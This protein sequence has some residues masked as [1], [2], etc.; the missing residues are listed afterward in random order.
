MRKGII[1]DSFEPHVFLVLR[2]P[3]F[4]E[5]QGLQK[6]M[7]DQSY[8]ITCTVTIIDSS[9]TIQMNIGIF[10]LCSEAKQERRERERKRANV[11]ISLKGDWHCQM[12]RQLM[13]EV[14]LMVFFYKSLLSHFL[15]FLIKKLEH[16]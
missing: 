4:E 11:L 3:S 14:H 6:E 10:L 2:R 5:T 9:K 8:V 1:V 13:T 15:H 12:K 7:H 16:T